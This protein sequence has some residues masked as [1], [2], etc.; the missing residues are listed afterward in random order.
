MRYILPMALSFRFVTVDNGRDRREESSQMC[1]MKTAFRD[2]GLRAQSGNAES[3]REGPLCMTA[4][5]RDNEMTNVMNYN[6]RNLV[7]LT[8]APA[9]RPEDGLSRQV[10]AWSEQMMLV[11]HVM[12]AG[13]SG[14]RHSHPHEQLVYIV[15][16][17]LRITSGDAVFEAVS[18][19]SFVVP[20]GVEHQASAL[21][22]S[23]VLDIFSPFREDYASLET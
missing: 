8:A 4:G 15:R 23:E 1:W 7:R 20:G 10:L 5:M 22:E 21:E 14:L 17:H 12:R 13:W 11:R 6:G 18:G 16:G 2:F 9:S 19:D 3:E